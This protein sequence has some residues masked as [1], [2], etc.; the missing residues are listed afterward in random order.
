MWLSF[1][2]QLEPGREG[3]GRSGMMVAPYEVGHKEIQ[4]GFALPMEQSPPARH[5]VTERRARMSA[6][7]SRQQVAFILATVGDLRSWMKRLLEDTSVAKPGFQDLCDLSEQLLSAATELTSLAIQ[8][9]QAAQV[10]HRH[11]KK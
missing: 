7:N 1:P 6:G 4:R 5:F 11:E 2:H 9:T 10:L 3:L 8:V